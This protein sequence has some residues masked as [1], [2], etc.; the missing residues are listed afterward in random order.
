MARGGVGR[1]CAHAGFI[2]YDYMEVG[3]FM[4]LR[5][6]KYRVRKAVSAPIRRTH[7]KH[8][9]FPRGFPKSH[10]LPIFGRLI[11]SR[12][13]RPNYGFENGAPILLY[14]TQL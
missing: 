5:R 1:G 9:P 12:A 4:I 2:N 13:A 8:I 7:R 6:A 11:I 10:G 14:G 3:I